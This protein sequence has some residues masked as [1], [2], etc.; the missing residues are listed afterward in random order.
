M[1]R[2]RNSKKLAEQPKSRAQGS[3]SKEARTDESVIRAIEPHEGPR[4]LR[5]GFPLVGS[6]VLEAVG[7]NG[8]I[9]RAMHDVIHTPDDEKVVNRL[10][11]EQVARVAFRPDLGLGDAGAEF[12]E[13]FGR[14]FLMAATSGEDIGEIESRTS[15]ESSDSAPVLQEVGMS[16][17]LEDL[18]D[19]ADPVDDDA[20]PSRKR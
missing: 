18:T 8:R 10:G 20:P 4:T 14:E 9:G 2:N 11:P 3:V 17:E 7:S 12:A 16:I 15:S 19:F 13:E 5:T 6:E 1:S